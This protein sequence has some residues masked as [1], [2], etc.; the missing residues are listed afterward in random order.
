MVPTHAIAQVK[1]AVEAVAAR[2]SDKVRV[3]RGRKV[4]ELRPKVD[5]D[6]GKAL[7]H[8][9]AALGLAGSHDVL[10]IYI[11]DDR[12]DEDAFA[13]LGGGRGVGV[14]VSSV[15]K[16]TAAAYTLSG[17]DQVCVTG[18]LVPFAAVAPLNSLCMHAYEE[19]VHVPCADIRLICTLQQCPVLASS[20]LK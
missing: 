15:D 8:I 18:E 19:G 1:A 16:S 13:V 7:L 5:W 9:L 11:G 17:P 12:T 14:L 10:P 2:H 3:T 20:W 4:L 6:K